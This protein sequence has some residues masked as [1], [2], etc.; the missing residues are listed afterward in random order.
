MFLAKQKKYKICT[1]HKLGL[2]GALIHLLVANV[3][4]KCETM[5]DLEIYCIWNKKSKI[6]FYCFAFNMFSAV[7]QNEQKDNSLN[8]NRI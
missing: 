4:L 1:Q 6:K 2:T 3:W 8:S 7:L 5:S